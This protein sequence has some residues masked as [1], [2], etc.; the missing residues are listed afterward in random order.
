MEKHYIA[1][2]L[3]VVAIHVERGYAESIIAANGVGNST[4]LN[5]LPKK[6]CE[7]ATENRTV[8]T[9]WTVDNADNDE[10]FWGSG[11]F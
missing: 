8:S 9:N 10:G 5:E 7:G 11:G 4:F 3:T 2:S 1:P 6:D